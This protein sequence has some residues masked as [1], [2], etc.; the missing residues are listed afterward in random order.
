MEKFSRSIKGQSDYVHE[1]P[2]L[3]ATD[4]TK[5]S[6]NTDTLI[7]ELVHDIITTTNGEKHCVLVVRTAE[8]SS[9]GTTNF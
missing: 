1:D 4:S 7:G 5:S 8:P 6:K 2:N 3:Y 9:T